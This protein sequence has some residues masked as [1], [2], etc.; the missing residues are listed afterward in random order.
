MGEMIDTLG[1]VTMNIRRR[2]DTCPRH[3]RG[4]AAA[5]LLVA[6]LACQL[7]AARAAEVSDCD[8]SGSK[9]TPSPQGRWVVNVQEEVCAVG[10]GVAAGITVVVSSPEGPEQGGR[11]VMIGVPRSRD[12]WPRVRWRSETELEVWVPNLAVVVSTQARWQGVQVA[13]RY[14]GDNPADREAVAAY[15][16][17]MKAW[18][19]ETT[20]WVARRKQD[21]D[22]AG[23]RP[24]RPEEPRVA[25][26][27]C[28]P[29]D[30]ASSLSPSPSS[31]A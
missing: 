10:N 28:D 13:L 21:P 24:V 11:V 17:A 19:Q 1:M 9:T 3:P 30:F 26:G 25:A 7:P 27:R 16:L 29:A 31:R 8:R 6:V 20:A 18:Q 14:C 5:L 22:N 23:P 4:V 15:K 12:D 2:Y